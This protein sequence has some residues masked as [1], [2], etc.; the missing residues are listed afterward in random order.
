M[1]VLV[2]CEESQRVCNAFRLK[3]HNAFSCDILECSGGHPEWH[4]KIDVLCLIDGGGFRTMDGK[5]HFIPGWD[6]I[7]A[8]PPCTYLTVSGNRWFDISKYGDKARLRYQ[9]RIK[10]V[11]FFMSIVNAK[12]CKIAIENPIGIMSTYFRKPDQIIQPY[13]FG[14]HARK[15][16]CLWLKNLPLLIPTDIVNPGPINKYGMSINGNLDCARIDGKI[17]SWNDPR[18]KIIRSKTYPGIALAMAEQWGSEE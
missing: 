10:A 4:I 9:E 12:C 11:K 3:G 14:D 2:A 1:N 15:S 13:Y 18:T 16:T 17:I 8:H 7:I 5:Y 6:L